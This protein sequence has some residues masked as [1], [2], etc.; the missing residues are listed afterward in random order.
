MSLTVFSILAFLTLLSAGA[1]VCL[2]KVLHSALALL[3]CL[4]LLAV[5]YLFLGSEFLAVLQILIYAGAIMVLL[6]IGIVLFGS[7]FAGKKESGWGAVLL[8]VVV[9]SGLLFALSLAIPFSPEA[10]REIS[11][12]PVTAL[13]VSDIGQAFLEKYYLALEMLG[14]LLLL[15]TIGVVMLLQEKKL[16]L[17]AGRGLKA[18]QQDVQEEGK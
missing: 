1:V 8:G 9:A 11:Q 7:A 6:V 18:K 16:P 17:S 2:P 10:F 15:V 4:C 3:C 13:W 5:H 12:Q 14:V